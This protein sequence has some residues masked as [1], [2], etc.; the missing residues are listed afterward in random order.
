MDLLSDKAGENS[1]S[2]VVDVTKNE[3]NETVDIREVEYTFPAVKDSRFS[4]TTVPKPELFVQNSDTLYSLQPDF[5]VQFP[6]K[7]ILQC[8]E[9]STSSARPPADLNIQER[10]AREREVC[11]RSK[12]RQEDNQCNSNKRE[13]INANDSANDDAYFH[14][15]AEVIPDVL[16]TNPILPG[17]YRPSFSKKNSS[18][19]KRQP[20]QEHLPSQPLNAT[21]K[22]SVKVSE[23]R[24]YDHHL[25][26]EE[27]RL[28]SQ[29]QLTYEKYRLHVD[30][31][32]LSSLKPKL[33]KL[34]PEV[35]SLLTSIYDIG[36]AKGIGKDSNA[37]PPSKALQSYPLFSGIFN[38]LVEIVSLTLDEVYNTKELG[39]TL[40]SIWK[41]LQECRTRQKFRSTNAEV[42]VTTDSG[43]DS[44]GDDC[45]K[46]IQQLANCLRQVLRSLNAEEFNYLAAEGVSKHLT[47]QLQNLLV[48]TETLSS[49]VGA[50]ELNVTLL[51][52]SKNYA[53]FAATTN[54]EELVRRR[55]LTSERYFLRLSLEKRFIGGTRPLSLTW[56]QFSLPFEHSFEYDLT[57]QPNN[58]AIELVQCAPG[59]SLMLFNKV[60]SSTFIG[61]S[62]ECCGTRE[63]E[64][65]TIY[66]FA[67]HQACKNKDGHCSR[68]KGFIRVFVD[69]DSSQ[70][71]KDRIESTVENLVC[72]PD[73]KA[74][75][76]FRG[77]IMPRRRYMMAHS[78][79]QRP[80]CASKIMK[81]ETKQDKCKYKVS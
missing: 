51:E 47:N 16:F 42:V 66:Q 39:S 56:P 9:G 48:A 67:S 43:K 44:G 4:L 71:R 6:T 62:V 63:I 81:W 23:V 50:P 8:P 18:P 41:N 29:L 15:A 22:L 11:S 3:L 65:P 20:S 55:R 64:T 58:M 17:C 73:L 78:K 79:I 31:S 40:W 46:Y 32:A 59:A 1:D 38:E 69:L 76:Q 75:G 52:E 28:C 53:T 36:E 68:L 25:F 24:F 35:V 57:K 45:Q 49:V 37:E 2:K 10:L 60:I 72:A 7:S 61:T 30:A 27:E 13:G 19:R 14:E 21:L 26:I 33:S 80:S 12:N 70:S 34:I 77:L 54:V 74:Q 5:N